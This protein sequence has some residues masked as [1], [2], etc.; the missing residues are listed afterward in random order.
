MVWCGRCPR[1][2]CRTTLWLG[3][4]EPRN[5]CVRCTRVE[6][7]LSRTSPCLL[8]T[9]ALVR[10]AYS[11]L[12]GF[13]LSHFGDAYGQKT[14]GAILRVLLELCLD[15][16]SCLGTRGSSACHNLRDQ[17]CCYA[18]PRR[19]SR[20][21]SARLH[22]SSQRAKALEPR[23]NP[24]VARQSCNFGSALPAVVAHI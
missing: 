21:R 8:C 24:A 14:V 20:T 5:R 4:C 3:L 16:S 11:R 6:T 10:C 19:G 17:L 9:A 2:S 7:A 13:G 12:A 1:P 15:P 18:R 22:N 23:R